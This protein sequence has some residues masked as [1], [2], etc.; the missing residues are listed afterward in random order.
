MS[1]KTKKVLIL[2]KKK[3]LNPKKKKVIKSKEKNIKNKKQT[4]GFNI[5]KANSQPIKIEN[6][7][8]NN[9]Q[10]KFK[11]T[12]DKDGTIY[13]LL[14]FDMNDMNNLIYYYCKNDDYE[15]L[16]K[17]NNDI[18]IYYRP[19]LEIEKIKI[20]TYK[21]I[22]YFD[23]DIIPTNSKS[24]PKSYPKRSEIKLK[25][26]SDNIKKII[27][28]SIKIEILKKLFNLNPGIINKI[29]V[30][31]KTYDCVIDNLYK[32]DNNTNT[33]K[34]I[35]KITEIEG[36]PKKIYIKMHYT[37]TIPYKYILIYADNI[38]GISTQLGGII[39]YN[40]ILNQDPILETSTSNNKI[41][42]YIENLLSSAQTPSAK[43]PPKP[44]R[45]SSA[46]SAQPAAQVAQTPP[47]KPLK[48]SKTPL[49]QTAAQVAPGAQTAQTA[50]PAKT[51]SPSPFT[52]KFFR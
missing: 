47:P 26:S 33:I 38:I 20:Y 36:D 7:F 3:I 25:N 41:K 52:I 4:G 19:I 43:P 8:K 21:F 31:G 5:I 44:V 50:Q 13:K 28:D 39:G 16:Q 11:E 51:P 12:S 14:Y 34:I 35:S 10:Q 32:F 6:F 23:I 49:S 45:Q 29:E 1:S 37:L 27:N 40:I 17:G 9:I 15:K 2:K 46:V 22:Y 48:P 24:Y 18:Y 30:N 42:K